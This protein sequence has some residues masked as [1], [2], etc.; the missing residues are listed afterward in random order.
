MRQRKLKQ[1]GIEV[2]E[3]SGSDIADFDFES[4]DTDSSQMEEG[5]QEASDISSGMLS[6]Q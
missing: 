2:E 6:D 1:Q 3:K 5:S 4:K